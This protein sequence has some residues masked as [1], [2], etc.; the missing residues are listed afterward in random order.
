MPTK[1]YI[2]STTAFTISGSNFQPGAT[3]AFTRTGSSDLTPDSLTVVSQKK[4]T[5]VL[6][7]PT[8]TTADTWDLVITTPDGGTVT[9]KK[10][11]QVVPWPLPRIT[12]VTPTTGAMGTPV[13]FT[14]TGTNFQPGATTVV[15]N[16]TGSP[17]VPATGVTVTSKTQL[18]GTVTLPVVGKW[19]LL[20]T[21]VDGG[22]SV[23]KTTS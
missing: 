15:F 8:G 6:T 16:K 1:A 22:T 4:I 23:K 17:D 11:L 10:A 18:A 21:T 9:K 19:N 7:V 13:S 12:K 3:V 5:G 14:V 20:V 2:N